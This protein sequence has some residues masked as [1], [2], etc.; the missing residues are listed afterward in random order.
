MMNLNQY[1]LS[2]DIF[3]QQTETYGKY[4]KLYISSLNLIEVNYIL[5]KIF[6]P[7]NIL[8][9]KILKNCNYDVFETIIESKINTDIFVKNVLQ[10]HNTSSSL[11][12]NKNIEI[13]DLLTAINNFIFYYDSNYKLMFATN[14]L[15]DKMDFSMEKLCMSNVCK[16][17]KSTLFYMNDLVCDAI[18]N[19]NYKFLQICFDWMVNKPYTKFEFNPFTRK[20]HQEIYKWILN[21]LEKINQNKS[22]GWKEGPNSGIWP[23]TEPQDYIETFK[24]IKPFVKFDI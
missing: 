19:A 16:N 20:S 23:S 10:N 13:E 9:Y 18:F 5:Q 22:V 7:D 1:K 17:Y 12:F 2:R 4:L 15:A 11:T 3:L 14:L 21:N 6:V 8:Q 24:I